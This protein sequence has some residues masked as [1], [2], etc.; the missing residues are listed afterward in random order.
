MAGMRIALRQYIEPAVTDVDIAKEPILVAVGRG[1]QNQDNL[2]LAEELAEALGGVVCASRPV[3]DQGWLPPTRLVGK[4]GKR[5]RPKLYLALGISGAP[6][7]VQAITDSEVIVAVNI[8]PAAPIFDVAQYG[9]IVD[10]F[11]LLPVLTE[12]IRQARAELSRAA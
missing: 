3:V 12:K 1:I 10:L 5:V 7:H 11:D 4:S 9:A 8:D 6:E 2:S